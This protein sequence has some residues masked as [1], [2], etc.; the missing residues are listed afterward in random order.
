MLFLMRYRRSCQ[1]NLYLPRLVI[2]LLIQL[3]RPQLLLLLS[4]RLLLPV[5]YY[6]GQKYPWKLDPYLHLFTM[7]LLLLELLTPIL[8][9]AFQ[10][11]ILVAV[12][13]VMIVI[14]G[15]V[16]PIVFLALLQG[17]LVLLVAFVAEVQPVF[18]PALSIPILCFLVD[19]VTLAIL[20]EHRLLV[21][22]V[23]VF[24]VVLACFVVDRAVL[25]VLV[26]LVLPVVLHLVV[27]VVPQLTFPHL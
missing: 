12:H 14:V 17:I 9:P 15:I 23:L 21:L 4:Q 26:V 3:Y 5:G 1:Q 16:I 6:I 19:R 20:V 24:E 7:L 8:D 13:E 18:P 25:A 22:V 11:M 10:L 2:L 27:L